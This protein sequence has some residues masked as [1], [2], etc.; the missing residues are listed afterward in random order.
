MP[1]EGD[2]KEMCGGPSKSSLFEMHFCDA[3]ADRIK[4][5]GEMATEAI[6]K[7]RPLTKEADTVFTEAKALSDAWQLGVCSIEPQGKQV[8]SLNKGWVDMGNEANVAANEAEKAGTVLEKAEKGLEEAKTAVEDAGDKVTGEQAGKQDKAVEA[9]K[10]AAVA[11]TSDASALEYKLKMLA[12]PLTGDKVMEKWEDHFEALGDTKKNWH[13]VCALEPIKGQSYIGLDD[14]ET[15][16]AACA[17]KCFSLVTGTDH[18][19]GFNYQSINGLSACQ[20][21]TE[22]GLTKPGITQSVP[23]F[24]V[25]QTKIDDMKLSDLDCYTKKAFMGSHPGGPLKTDVVK[26]VT[27]DF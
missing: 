27:V 6:D 19:V 8:C 9:V 26:K 4:M 10:D 13:A 2:N 16:K 11:L 23:I 1:C 14:K 25:S 12:G 3:S 21:L 15:G 22:H 18:C 20:L 24:E 17:G 5:V 7:A